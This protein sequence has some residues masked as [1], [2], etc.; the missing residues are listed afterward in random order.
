MIRGMADQLTS[1][2]KKAL[3]EDIAGAGLGALLERHGFQ[4]VPRSKTHWRLDGDRITWRVSIH[5][6]ERCHRDDQ[7]GEPDGH[8]VNVASGIYFDGLSEWLDR[9]PYKYDRPHH[10]I[11]PGT[12]AKAHLA[13][14]LSDDIVG[15]EK[16]RFRKEVGPQ[17]R[18]GKFLYHLHP[19]E[20]V[21]FNEWFDVPDMKK[22]YNKD[23][24]YLLL[25][26]GDVAGFGQRLATLFEKYGLPETQ[27][28]RT[29]EDGYR[30]WYGPESPMARHMTTESLV[31]A[32][33]ADDHAFIQ[34]IAEKEFERAS[35]RFEELKATLHDR[36]DVNSPT[37]SKREMN[38][39]EW[40]TLHRLTR[41]GLARL[42]LEVTRVLELDIRNPGIDFD[43]IDLADRDWGEKDYVPDL[44][45]RRKFKAEGNDWTMRYRKFPSF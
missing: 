36:I 21:T 3:K 18:L 45:T 5:Y 22:P 2:E 41:L 12:G 23:Y 27:E 11:L 13:G 40:A 7:F 29:L 34:K 43:P 19:F 33:L 44:D 25:K 31:M 14:L 24:Y 42:F 39:N 38:D 16:Q 17:T 6:W 26:E 37:A 20:H 30:R 32:K 4:L 15:A 9:L 10:S 28:V 8:W 1:W 35:V